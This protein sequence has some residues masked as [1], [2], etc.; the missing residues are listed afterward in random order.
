MYPPHGSVEVLPP[1]LPVQQLPTWQCPGQ[2]E[3]RPQAAISVGL[4]MR[5]LSAVLTTPHAHFQ[6]RVHPQPR[7]H[8]CQ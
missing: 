5:S 2:S 1:Q 4:T 3:C 6:Q 8:Q 7:L